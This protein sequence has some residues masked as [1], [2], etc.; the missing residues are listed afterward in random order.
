MLHAT[1]VHGANA[2]IHMMTMEWKYGDD[3]V[4]ED[5]TELKSDT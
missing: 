4:D 2:A 5:D 1:I 3:E